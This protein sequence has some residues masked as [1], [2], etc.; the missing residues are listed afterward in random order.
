[1]NPVLGEFPSLKDPVFI[2]ATTTNNSSSSGT[3]IA[4]LSESLYS[5]AQN[6]SEIVSS[7]N[8]TFNGD[9]DSVDGKENYCFHS[10]KISSKFHIKKEKKKS[11]KL[12]SINSIYFI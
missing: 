1:M 6:S 10:S 11:F 4:I 5:K 3:K 7:G 8:S 12:V 2:S 9:L